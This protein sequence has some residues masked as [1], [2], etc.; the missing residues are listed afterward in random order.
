[1]E[2]LDQLRRQLQELAQS[3][4]R[5]WADDAS[6]VIN[7]ETDGDEQRLVDLSVELYETLCR[8]FVAH[9]RKKTTPE[10]SR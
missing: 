1:M 3:I 6:K 9:V 7:R 10:T 8:E 2:T 4:G 5:Q